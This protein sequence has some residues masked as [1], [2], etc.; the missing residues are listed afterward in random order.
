MARHSSSFYLKILFCG[1]LFGS[2]FFSGCY[3][4]GISFNG[5]LNTVRAPHSPEKSY[6]TNG[7]WAMGFFPA[8]MSKNFTWQPVFYRFTSPELSYSEL[9]FKFGFAEKWEWEESEVDLFIGA[10]L[11]RATV[12]AKLYQDLVSL[13]SFNMPRQNTITHG[14]FGAGY[15]KND[16]NWAYGLQ[17]AWKAL[18]VEGQANTGGGPFAFK[19]TLYRTDLS[20]SLIYFFF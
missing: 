19:N 17:L 12:E 16:S 9:E 13:E 14:L 4:P 7:S 8:D 11:G 10:S 3:K 1:L 18:P 20:L 15:L 5:G 2:L 6:K